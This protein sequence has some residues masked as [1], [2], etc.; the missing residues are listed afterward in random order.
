MR[1]SLIAMTLTALGVA[2]VGTSRAEVVVHLRTGG[3]IRADRAWTE[4]D[5]VH[6]Q[7]G[8]DVASFA[9]SAVESIEQ[10]PGGEHGAESAGGAADAAQNAPR[11]ATKT[12][13]H[14]DVH[15]SAPP[16]KPTP[17]ARKV[18]LVPTVQGEDTATKLDRLDALSLQAHREL[19][20]ARH[21][22]DPQEKLKAL[23]EKIDDINSQREDAMRKLGRMR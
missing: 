10:V 21:N 4:G 13:Q 7:M 2:V 22:G 19:T 9:P 6:V 5:T 20:I 15:P 14:A 3:T 1:R 23:Q 17:A 8:S 12:G 18:D 11:S 16:A